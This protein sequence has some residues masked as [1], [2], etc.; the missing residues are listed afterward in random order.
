M[1]VLPPPLKEY[2]FPF[3]IGTV[4]T[5][6]RPSL[7]IGDDT[8]PFLIGTVRTHKY[9]FYKQPTYEFP[10]LIGTVRTAYSLIIFR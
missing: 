9:G 6:E 2:L 3:L 8:F 5:L 4:R 1:G 10:F 7:C